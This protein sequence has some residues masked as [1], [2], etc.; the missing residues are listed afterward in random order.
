M[1]CRQLFFYLPTNII[2]S[3]D[4]C[5]YSFLP[6]FH[7]AK[8]RETK[9]SIPLTKSNIDLTI[10]IQLEIYVCTDTVHAPDVSVFFC[11][12]IFRVHSHLRFVRYELLRELFSPYNCKN[13]YTTHPIIKLFSPH[14]STLNSKC[15]GT[16]L[17][18]YKPLL[19]VN[20]PLISRIF[21][22]VAMEV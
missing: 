1:L 19:S 2:K 5:S 18:Q 10:Q 17:V 14:K 4:Q 13:G 12:V 9:P 8:Q 22:P 6:F 16:H 15:E 3:H 7:E 20:G 11:W 21:S